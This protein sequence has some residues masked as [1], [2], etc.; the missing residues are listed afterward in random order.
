L[1]RGHVNLAEF[2]S[3]SCLLRFESAAEDWNTFKLL[4]KMGIA[5]A[6]DE[7]Y[8][9]MDEAEIDLL[10]Y[11]RGWLIKPR[12]VY[13]GFSRLLRR[14]QEDVQG[15]RARC[16]NDM[17]DIL[18]FFDKRVC[19]RYLSD[20]GIPVP[21][22]FASPRDFDEVRGHCRSAGRLMIKLAHGS[23][24]AG[25]VALHWS[26]GRLRALTTV[27]EATVGGQDR[28]Y[29]SKKMRVLLDE[30]EIANLINRLCVEKVQA[31]EWLPKAHWQ[32]NNFDL[33]VVTIA[34]KS[35]HT[36]ARVSAS[37]FTNLTLGG[38]RGNV[39]AIAKRMGTT[40]W[41]QM[42]DTCTRVAD[43]FP[44]SF[45]MGIDVLISPDFQQYAVLEVNAFG[46]WLL[47]EL[48][49]GEDTYGAILSAWEGQTQA[50]AV[51]S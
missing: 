46:D 2:L 19:Q 16:L 1:L 17:K 21:F 3:H 30:S 35:R 40:A 14:L 12:Q 9:F 37:P 29:S 50:T 42:R 47:H 48:D 33:R 6:C 28:L 24:A 32:G 51:A 11:E 22:S 5:P 8:P 20:A 44:R 15:S 26:Q 10:T 45:S 49:C 23:G 31:E 43:R 36:V 4:L 27:V 34:G 13:L 7:G 41:G 18:V 38:R 39:A 25:C